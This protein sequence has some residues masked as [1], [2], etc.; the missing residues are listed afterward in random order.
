M[1]Q[2]PESV[3]IGALTYEIRIESNLTDAVNCWAHIRH[4]PQIIFL[5]DRNRPDR[6]RVALW[7]EIKHA[8]NQLA[9]VEDET[10][11]EAAT[12][13]QSPMEL[14]VLRQ[15]PDLVAYLTSED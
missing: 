15:N 5:N 9:N 7:H 4:E 14:M 11:E 6:M 12:T 10:T 2:P 1:N 8:V 3:L 13:V